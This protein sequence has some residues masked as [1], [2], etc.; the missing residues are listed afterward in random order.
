MKRWHD[1]ANQLFSWYTSSWKNF[2]REY[3]ENQEVLLA[4]ISYFVSGENDHRRGGATRP[5]DRKE[6][7]LLTL[8]LFALE[9]FSKN[10]C[11]WGTVWGRTI[12][13]H[14]FDGHMLL[15]QNPKFLRDRSSGTR[16]IRLWNFFEKPMYQENCLR[17]GLIVSPLRLS[18]AP[19]TKSRISAGQTFWLSIYS[20]LN[21]FRI[22]YVSG[23][24]LE[25]GPYRATSSMVICSG[26][27]ILNFCEIDLLALDL[28]ALEFLLKNL[29]IRSSAG[30]CLY[31][32][33]NFCEKNLLGLEISPLEFFSNVLYIKRS[34][35][36][37]APSCHLPD[38][39]MLLIQYPHFQREIPSVPEDIPTVVLSGNRFS[40]YWGIASKFSAGMIL[41]VCVRN[42]YITA[43]C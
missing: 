15:I 42:N 3:L 7:D 34:S 35:R 26:Y 16:N 43:K 5:I 41:C 40:W 32:I 22:T 24:T 36:W 37:I 11:I 27:K 12:P 17:W 29:C 19:D 13:C 38:T 25:V 30:G 1:K 20:R 6:I 14:H 10:V 21:F 33:R 31:K 23:E 8:D 39:N 4:E 18:Y 9:Y 28:F 2:K